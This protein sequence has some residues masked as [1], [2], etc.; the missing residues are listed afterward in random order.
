MNSETIKTVAVII[1]VRRG[2]NKK[3]KQDRVEILTERMCIR[4]LLHSKSTE[5]ST[6]DEGSTISYT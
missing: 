4:G 3:Q 1:S 5:A 2:T 6:R